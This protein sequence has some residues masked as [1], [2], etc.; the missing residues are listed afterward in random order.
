[1]RIIPRQNDTAAPTVFSFVDGLKEVDADLF[2]AHLKYAAF[3]STPCTFLDGSEPISTFVERYKR[4][5]ESKAQDKNTVVLC[6]WTHE[7]IMQ[8]VGQ[9]CYDMNLRCQPVQ[10]SATD[11]KLMFS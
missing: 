5:R 9:A 10:I 7:R 2:E 4:W 3:L 11:V 8:F 1:M 6:K